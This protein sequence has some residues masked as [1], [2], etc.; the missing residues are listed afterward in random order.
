MNHKHYSHLDIAANIAAF[1]ID[2]DRKRLEKEVLSY[3]RQ[4]EKRLA[5][6]QADNEAQVERIMLHMSQEIERLKQ[7]LEIRKDES[8]SSNANSQKNVSKSD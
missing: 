2:S 4:T 3:V 8:S 5:T 7:E 6:Q 1:L